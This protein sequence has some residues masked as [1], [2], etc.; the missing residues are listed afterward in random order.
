MKVDK[1]STPRKS[2]SGEIF[3]T[4]KPVEN[5]KNMFWSWY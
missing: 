5:T 2:F 3:S 4:E 1:K